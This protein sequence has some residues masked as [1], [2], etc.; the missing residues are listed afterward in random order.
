MCFSRELLQIC[1]LFEGGK[2]AVFLP[3]LKEKV[4]EDYH[5]AFEKNGRVPSKNDPIWA[6]IQSTYNIPK[7]VTHASIYTAMLTKF[8]SRKKQNEEKKD[9][10]EPELS[11]SKESKNLEEC[12]EQDNS[13]ASGLDDSS[14]E[15]GKVDKRFYIDI[16]VNNWRRIQSTD[17]SYSRA[18]DNRRRNITR[19]YNVFLSDAKFT[20]MALSILF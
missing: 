1:V 15:I 17:R 11:R 4:F 2:P 20:E 18:D 12:T 3:E 16:G 9:H 14:E 8:N 6:T 10:T 13:D 19:K 5:E 7:A